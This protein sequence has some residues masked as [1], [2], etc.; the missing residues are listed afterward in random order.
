MNEISF[1][2][3]GELSEVQSHLLF[4]LNVLKVQS[5][6]PN[7]SGL[8]A[9]EFR[10]GRETTRKLTLDLEN[11]ESEAVLIY[12]YLSD[13]EMDVLINNKQ[14]IKFYILPHRL[15]D[16]DYIRDKILT[17]A[18]QAW[19]IADYSNSSSV[20]NYHVLKKALNSKNMLRITSLGAVSG[21]KAENANS[22]Q[23]PIFI[24]F[25]MKIFFNPANEIKY[26]NSRVLDRIM[27]L[28]LCIQYIFLMILFK[29]YGLF[30]DICTFSY[31][32]TKLIIL[33]PFF[34]I[35][36]FTAFQYKK[37]IKKHDSHGA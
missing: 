3:Y 17:K 4:R 19:I 5:A 33:Y 15:F 31:R 12:R 7:R 23:W 36:W 20:Q 16:L 35:Y 14:N 13:K 28:R 29:T 2:F 32:K 25:L 27:E 8:Y 37:R 34:K 21:I 10:H 26:S 30:F 1:I 9:V 22:I 6:L 11:I 24:L 18:A